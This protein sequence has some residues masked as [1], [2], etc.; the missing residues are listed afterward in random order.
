MAKPAQADRQ[1]G[2]HGSRHQPGRPPQGPG[3]PTQQDG[4][5]R[6]A[7]DLQ[8]QAQAKGPQTKAKIAGALKKTAAKNGNARFRPTALRLINPTYLGMDVIP[9]KIADGPRIRR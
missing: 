2:E 7:R 4:T 3:R 6:P 5:G 9:E 8:A 1:P